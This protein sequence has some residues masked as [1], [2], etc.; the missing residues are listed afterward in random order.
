[1]CLEDLYR[2]PFS[3]YN[4]NT[5]NS[6]Q[7]IEF[8]ESPFG[9]YLLD[10][11]EEEV[12]S[13][14]T[15]IVFTGGRG[16]GKTMLLKHFS[17]SSQRERAQLENKNLKD[18]LLDQGC[19]GLYIRFDSPLLIGFEGL[20]ISQQQ[21]DVIFTHFFEMTICKTYVE[22]FKILSEENVIS[23]EDEELLTIGLVDILGYEIND[24][25]NLDEIARALSEDINYVNRYRSEA[26]F[27]D[28][29]FK[30]HKI[31]TFGSLQYITADLFKKSCKDLMDINNLIL[32][33]EYENF[34]AFE[35]KIVN[36]AIKFSK[37]IAFR[38][39]MRPVG[40][41]TFAT[42][43]DNEFI[44]EHRDYKNVVFDNPLIKKSN[45]KYFDFLYAIAEKRLSQVPIFKSNGL[46]DI[47]KILGDKENYEQE[48]L[49]IVKGKDKHIQEYLQ[50]IA[51]LNKRKNSTF[52]KNDERLKKLYYPENPLYEMQNMRMLLKPYPIEYVVKAFEDYLNNTQSE[53]SKKYR[54][55]YINKYRFSYLFVLCS[56]YKVES[57]QY[58]GFNDFAYLSSGIVGTFL[59]LCRCSFQ[60]AY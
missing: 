45:S 43:S 37:N 51:K 44:K 48:A 5:L 22:T 31:Y 20:G 34:L 26:I 58:Y 50:E 14:K 35:Q 2:N 56:I 57:K 60:Y 59:E 7:I 24:I 39:G 52:N 4:A 33:D 19:I 53:E 32:L 46:I 30:P 16:T 54:N 55:D 12:V 17:L 38:V 1:M 6:Q 41:H 8:W 3:D 13:E 15:A 25:N 18:Y 21:W 28:C 23:K 9:N 47:K 27:G 11:R 42:V 36:S 49:E 29:E 40:F 10:I